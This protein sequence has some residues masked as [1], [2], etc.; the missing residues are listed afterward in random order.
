MADLAATDTT[1]P[2]VVSGYNPTISVK[3]GQAGAIDGSIAA[4]VT[5]IVI[6]AFNSK[7][8]AVPEGMATV[9]SSVV[10]LVIS[11]VVVAVKRYVGNWLKNKG[12]TIPQ[13]P[14]QPPT[15]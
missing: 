8:I 12:I 5:M 3:K 6:W 4:V 1:T 10:G 15:A 14:E 11:A 9:I 13:I 2:T 7:S